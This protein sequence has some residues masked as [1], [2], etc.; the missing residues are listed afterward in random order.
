MRPGRGISPVIDI[1]FAFTLRGGPTKGGKGNIQLV[2]FP[3]STLSPREGGGGVSKRRKGPS[4]F[5][6]REKG[7]SRLKGL[8]TLG[9]ERP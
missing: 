2:Q 8:A 3:L 4:A 5:T 7:G 9:R 6:L 1:I